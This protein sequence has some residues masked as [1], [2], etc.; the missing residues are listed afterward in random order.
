MTG[1]VGL[2]EI[3]FRPKQAA[4]VLPG[5][6]RLLLHS[7]PSLETLGLSHNRID[8]LQTFMCLTRKDFLSAEAR[9]STSNLGLEAL[10]N[11]HSLV[12]KNQP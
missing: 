4:G 10:K 6:R 9:T 11:E 5:I 12:F 2:M 3:S 7:L 8:T 1:T